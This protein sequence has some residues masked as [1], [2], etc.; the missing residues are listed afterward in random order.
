LWLPYNASRATLDADFVVA[1][2]LI[3]NNAISSAIRLAVRWNW[4]RTVP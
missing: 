2:P 3:E 4:N 1:A